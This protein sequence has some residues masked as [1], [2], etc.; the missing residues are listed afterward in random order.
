MDAS[1]R[2]QRGH[3]LHPAQQP[4]T[5]L[6]HAQGREPGGDRADPQV[7]HGR[8]DQGHGPDQVRAD[9]GDP[10]ADRATERVADQVHRAAAALLDEPGHQRGL[11]ADRAA[12]LGG[13]REPEAGQVQGVTGEG[14][15]PGGG[16]GAAEQVHEVGP[17]GGGTTE[18]VY[19]QTG[20]APCVAG[21]VRTNTSVSPR[22]TNSPGHTG[23]G[24]IDRL[25]ATVN[26][27]RRCST[28]PFKVNQ[29]TV[30][31]K[32]PVWAVT[33]SWRA[34]RVALRVH[35]AFSGPWP[36]WRAAGS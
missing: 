28:P 11:A 24:V 22:L 18:P 20:S 10:G 27:T 15:G 14:G 30:N 9:G 16:V 19:G 36:G 31:P 5:E 3:L 35:L 7:R 21:A 6:R 2:R 29:P 12:G 33:R 26:A 13:Q 32:H 1:T 8:G 23:F 4:G 34:T 25:P 17:V